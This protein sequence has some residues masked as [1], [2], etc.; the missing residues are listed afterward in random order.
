MKT[1]EQIAREMQDDLGYEDLVDPVKFASLVAIEFAKQIL[2]EAADNAKAKHSY[3]WTHN[4]PYVVKKSITEVLNK[5][6]VE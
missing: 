2:E 3:P 6:L 1:A 5:Y 4:E